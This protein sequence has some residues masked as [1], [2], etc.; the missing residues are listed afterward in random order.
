MIVQDIV[1]ENNGF[2]GAKIDDARSVEFYNLTSDA[3]GFLGTTSLESS[4]LAYKNPM[5]WR[6]HLAMYGARIV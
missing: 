5:I 3:N 4:G 1:L 6:V 2:S